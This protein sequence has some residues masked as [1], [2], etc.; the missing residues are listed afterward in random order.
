[1]KMIII[2][3]KPLPK[4][5]RLAALCNDGAWRISALNSKATGRVNFV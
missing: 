3:I 5:T 2:A 1:M 4:I